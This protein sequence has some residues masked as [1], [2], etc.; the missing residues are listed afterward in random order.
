[1][2][3]K[4]VKGTFYTLKCREEKQRRKKALQKIIQRKA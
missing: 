1:M 2:F 4:C 3:L